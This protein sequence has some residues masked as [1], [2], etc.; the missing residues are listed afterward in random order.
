M[1]NLSSL[2]RLEALHQIERKM[3]Q[4][5]ALVRIEQVSSELSDLL[6]EALDYGA[7]G[8]DW[9]IRSEGD[10]RLRRGELW[11][12]SR[13]ILE[14]MLCDIGKMQAEILASAFEEEGK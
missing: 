10:Q 4:L 1:K 12:L 9:A 11:C 8:I 6:E 3:P 7:M 2:Q 14:S 13:Q 5:W